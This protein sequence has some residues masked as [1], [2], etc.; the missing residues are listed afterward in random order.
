[1]A[2]KSKPP[3]E[4]VRV[5]GPITDGVFGRCRAKI[6]P[7]RQHYG[8][9]PLVYYAHEQLWSHGRRDPELETWI[10]LFEDVNLNEPIGS[11]SVSA[12]KEDFETLKGLN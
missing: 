3:F 5:K 4:V 12:F 2:K 8:D 1:M 9:A 7:V 6:G 11:V 10:F